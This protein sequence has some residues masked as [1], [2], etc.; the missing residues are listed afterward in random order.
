MVGISISH[1]GADT[2]GIVLHGKKRKDNTYDEKDPST[3]TAL[4]VNTDAV[5]IG[6]DDKGFYGEVTN[7][8][9]TV[10]VG[11][12]EKDMKEI[13]YGQTFDIKDGTYLLIGRQWLYFSKPQILGFPGAN[14][15]NTK[16]KPQGTIVIPTFK[17]VANKG[18]KPRQANAK[19]DDS[20]GMSIRF[21]MDDY[22]K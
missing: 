11:T 4:T 12:N 5:R 3:Y 17:D 21:S 20:L 13:K 15:V 2:D 7:K 16:D 18:M 6:C 22:H 9:A 10:Y 1:P 19:Q 8:R 14:K